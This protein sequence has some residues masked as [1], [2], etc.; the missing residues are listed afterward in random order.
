MSNAIYDC[1]D[2][3][4]V[5]V[6]CIEP[7]HTGCTGDKGE[8]LI[9]PVDQTPFVQATSICG[10]LRSYCNK[11]AKESVVEQ[12]FG[13]TTDNLESK[14]KFSDGKFDE[15][16]KLQLELRPKIQLDNAFGT[17]SSSEVKGTNEIKSG[18]KFDMQYVGAGAKFSFEIYIYGGTA[19]DKK[20]IET[21]LAALHAQ[22]IQFGG[23]KS[24]GC[25]YVKINK[26]LHKHYDMTNPTERKQWINEE[27]LTSIEILKLDVV[28]HVNKYRVEILAETESELL[29]KGIVVEKF[30]KE[31][32]KDMNIKNAE[33]RYI[34]PGSSFKGSIRNRME[35]IADYM[36]LNPSIIYDSF[37]KAVETSEDGFRGN[38]YFRDIIVGEENKHNLRTRIRIDKFTGGVMNGGLFS[39]LNIYG[40]M[41]IA[42]H[43]LDD[44][45]PDAVLGLFLLAIR[46]LA[47]KM[48]AIGSGQNVGKGYLTIKEIK[49]VDLKENT[50]CSLDSTFQ[51][52]G[53]SKIVNQCLVALKNQQVA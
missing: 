10:V 41:T 19:E 20:L 23:Q 11:I 47:H 48:Y 12:L 42:V 38:L 45:N 18:H 46:D 31:E 1:V 24:N 37:G 5:Y 15:E 22:E 33:G 27:G 21:G 30:G 40:D 13:G 17:M 52:S 32:P 43:L 7:M 51:V 50:S 26:L 29:I 35:M 36:S 34:I 25:G 3:Y 8:V 49:I 9:H 53:D 4:K 2:K 39:Q 6:T 16:S 44:K 28:N 14:I